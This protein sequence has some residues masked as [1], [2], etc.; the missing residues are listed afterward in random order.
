[1]I[2]LTIGITATEA[3]YQNYPLWIKGSNPDIEIINLSAS[4]F[5]DI[6]KCDGI[7]L[8]GGVDTHPKFYNN[9]RIYFPIAPKEFDVAR[10]ELEL[11]IFDYAQKKNPAIHVGRNNGDHYYQY[12]WLCSRSGLPAPCIGYSCAV[13]W[14][15]FVR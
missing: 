6:H 4:N 11:N 10:D 9:D 2:H 5:E 1:M 8:S 3:R 13:S 14:R 12:C 15:K 7:V